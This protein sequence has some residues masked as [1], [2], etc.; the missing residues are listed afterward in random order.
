VG[1]LAVLVG[2]GVFAAAIAPW[3]IAGTLLAWCTRALSL[4]RNARL[5]PK[6]TIQSATGI[7]SPRVVQTSMGLTGGSFNTREFVHGASLRAM[8][9]AKTGFQVLAFALPLVL[10]VA[11]LATGS[12]AAWFAAWICQAAGLL[13]ERWFF[14]AQARHPQNIYYQVVS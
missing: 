2:E 9:M 5:R 11:A 13:A 1:A 14:F 12:G 10:L 3:A 6:S 8:R 4:R 7:R